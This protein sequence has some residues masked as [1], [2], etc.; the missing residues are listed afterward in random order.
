MQYNIF[1]VATTPSIPVKDAVADVPE[2]KTGESFQLSFE[3]A[4]ETDLETGDISWGLT[5]QSFYVVDIIGT[6]F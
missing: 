2:M 1:S 3:L 5:L 4:E 6:V